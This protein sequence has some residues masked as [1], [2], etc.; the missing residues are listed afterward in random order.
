MDDDMDEMDALTAG[1]A[2]LATRAPFSLAFS[3]LAAYFHNH[4]EVPA[5]S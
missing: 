1:M 3:H 2:S 4:C 5:R